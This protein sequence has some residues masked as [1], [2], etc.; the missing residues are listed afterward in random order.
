MAT[1]E[2][3]ATRPNLPANRILNSTLKSFKSIQSEKAPEAS[4]DFIDSLSLGLDYLYTDFD[5]DTQYGSGDVEETVFSLSGLVAENTTLAFS[6]SHID[7]R[8]TSP[9]PDFEIE[10]HGY[11]LSLHHSLNENYGLGAYTFYQ[12]V[13][14]KNNNSNSFT[15]GFGGLFTTYHDLDLAVLSTSSSLTLVDYDYGYDTV[16]LTMADLSRQLN[17][18]CT[19]GLFA[20]WTDSLRSD[21]DFDNNYWLLGVEMRFDLDQWNVSIGFESAEDLDDYEGETVKVSVNYL[22]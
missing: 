16:F 11:D 14:I 12:M 10:A 6:Y 15:Y 17:D 1:F 2:T 9:S 22:F 7:Y 5:D 4:G 18:W 20:S 8:Y 21:P 3:N 13:D 19:L